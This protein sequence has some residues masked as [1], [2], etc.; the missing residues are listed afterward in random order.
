MGAGVIGGTQEI[1][2]HPGLVLWG[3]S[4]PGIH[5]IPFHLHPRK[6][7]DDIS[8]EGWPSLPGGHQTFLLFPDPFSTPVDE[9]FALLDHYAPWFISHWGNRQWRNG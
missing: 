8:F 2:E 5:V 4:N 6:K 9:L 7:R 3:L 1:E